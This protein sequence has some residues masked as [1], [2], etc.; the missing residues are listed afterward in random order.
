MR[1]TAVPGFIFSYLA[2]KLNGWTALILVTLWFGAVHV[3]QLTGSSMT[4]WF[5]LGMITAGGLLWTAV[6][7]KTGSAVPGM[8]CHLAYNGT[9]VVLFMVYGS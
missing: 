5:S 6:R 8:L 4:D 3:G 2:E 1:G 9:I 7:W